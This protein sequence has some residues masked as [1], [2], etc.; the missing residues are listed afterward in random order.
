M[1]NPRLIIGK[2]SVN[3]GFVFISDLFESDTN[4]ISLDT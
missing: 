1:V 4:F 3:A 2:T